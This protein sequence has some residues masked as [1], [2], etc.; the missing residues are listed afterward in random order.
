MS[1]HTTYSLPEVSDGQINEALSGL[2]PLRFL[3]GDPFYFSIIV[4]ESI[5]RFFQPSAANR[6][7][8]DLVLSGKR[9][10]ESYLLLVK[11]DVKNSN[12][13]LD[14]Y[15]KRLLKMVAQLEKARSQ[16][17]DV[18][19]LVDRIATEL[20]I[21]ETILAAINSKWQGQADAY[22]F[23]SN[24][25]DAIF[26]FSKAVSAINN[27]KPGLKDRYSVPIAD[28]NQNIVVPY[29]TPPDFLY[30]ASPTGRPRRIIY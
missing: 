25:G 19:P 26:G 1:A 20:E 14:S 5:Q 23:D 28:E 29:I 13:T 11:G 6:A 12:V 4:K 21:H 22:D 7:Q 24:F 27:I 15:S 2:V 8:F 10:K 30:E 9:V 16:N 18:V 17:Q 3:P